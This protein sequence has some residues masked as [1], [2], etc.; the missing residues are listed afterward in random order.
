MNALQIFLAILWNVSLLCCHFFICSVK[1]SLLDITLVYFYSSGL[2]FKDS[3]QNT[4][5]YINVLNRFSLVLIC[6]VIVL[7]FRFMYLIRFI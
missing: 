5:A 3:I 7:D 6:N 1:F 2:S 4:F